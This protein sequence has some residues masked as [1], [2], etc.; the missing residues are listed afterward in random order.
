MR[1]LI[2]LAAAAMGI[3]LA[4]GAQ[5]RELM[6]VPC[7]TPAAA[8]CD[9]TACIPALADRGNAVEA[10]S[11]RRFFLDYPCDLK[12][13]E[14]V[15]FVL[16]LHGAGSIGNWQRHYFP[17]IDVKDR[18]RLVVAT[19]TAATET[20][21]M[22]GGPAVRRWDAAADDRHLQDISDAVIAAVGRRNIRSFWLAGHSQGGMTSRRIVCSPY[23]RDKVD[24][25]LS[26]SGGRIGLAPT[27]ARFGP[28]LA[29]GSSPPPRQLSAALLNAPPPPCD[30][31][32]IYTTGE[33]EISNLPAT[34]PWAAR[35]GCTARRQERDIVDKV[36]GHVW[37]FSRA[38]YPVWGMRAGAGTARVWTYPGCRGGVVVADV[39]RMGKG[40]TEGLEPNV[41]EAIVR[42][43]ARAP[44]GKLARGS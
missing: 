35:Y 14:K 36:P 44:G 42:M 3:G 43:M 16:N 30:F 8:R 1:R 19:P 9:G 24:G 15:V 21:M 5:A 13:D 6:G 34:S 33:F 41:T 27:V 10:A 4:S 23:F 2:W 7:T 28:P 20:A 38:G 12:P 32:H 40:H 22:P 31:S 37:D 18:Y 29:D 26:L 25:M 39:V 17:A 11:G